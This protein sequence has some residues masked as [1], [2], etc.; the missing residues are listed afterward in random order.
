MEVFK[1]S[2]IYHV[3]DRLSVVAIREDGVVVIGNSGDWLTREQL[4]K[5][6]AD[7]T[8]KEREEMLNRFDE[9]AKTVL[10]IHPY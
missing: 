10:A 9:I 3:P 4:V 7:H 6:V 1:I 2:A 8:A 5:L